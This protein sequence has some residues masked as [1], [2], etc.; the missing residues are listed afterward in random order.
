MEG[1][2]RAHVSIDYVARGP[3]FTRHKDP[4]GEESEGSENSSTAKAQVMNE[5]GMQQP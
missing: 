2:E 1:V 5:I 3:Q 4:S